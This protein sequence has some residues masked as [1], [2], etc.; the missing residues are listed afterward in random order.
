MRKY[1]FTSL[2]LAIITVGCG[3]E[4]P[5]PPAT[6]V[7]P[8]PP[9]AQQIYSEFKDAANPLWTQLANKGVSNDQ[10]EPIAG[11]LRGL[12]SQNA[13]Q[14]NGPE[15][16]QRFESE[17]ADLVLAA[18][19]G[20][21]WRLTRFA[22]YAHKAI[23]PTSERFT[24]LLEQAEVIAAR[25]KV[26]IKGFAE[27]LGEGDE[28]SILL[29]VTDPATNIQFSYN[30]KEGE[31][32]HP[33]IDPNNRPINLLKAVRMIG[34]DALELEYLPISQLWTVSLQR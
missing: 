7:E 31:S 13:S 22:C 26:V 18:K 12:K 17:L 19:K 10:M 6:P 25:P 29:S 9:T 32:F 28:V 16:I 21:D 4:A 5:P 14:V 15:A 24:R 2:V 20:E 33:G 11:A 30:I 1:L 3:E 23:E 8:P 27:P 34:T